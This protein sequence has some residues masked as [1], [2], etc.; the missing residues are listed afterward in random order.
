VRC[1]GTEDR[2]AEMFMPA[3]QA[4]FGL[5]EFNVNDLTDLRFDDDDNAAA[6]TVSPFSCFNSSLDYDEA[7]TD[8]NETSKRLLVRERITPCGSFRCLPSDFS[9]VSFRFRD[10]N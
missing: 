6:A 9:L 8:V 4:P 7:F 2:P 5:V 10:A 1:H 3:I